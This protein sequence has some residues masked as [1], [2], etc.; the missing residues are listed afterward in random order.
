MKVVSI[1][2]HVDNGAFGSVD[3]LEP[4]GIWYYFFTVRKILLFKGPR[5]PFYVVR[6]L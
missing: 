1:S 6:F 2:Q 4:S 3:N 5:R